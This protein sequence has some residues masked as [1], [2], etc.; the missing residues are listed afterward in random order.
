[1]KLDLAEILSNVGMRFRYDVDEP[2][3]VDEDLECT[4]PVKGNI[5]FTNTGNVLLIEGGVK[6]KV[7][8]PCSRC[9][10]DYEQPV[11]APISEQF[12]LEVVIT[13]P[14]GRKGN[15][16]VEEDE[17]PSAGKL[18]EGHLLDLTELLRQSITLQIPSQP[19]HDETCKG[20]C[21]TCGRDLNEGPCGCV[22]APA[23]PAFAKLAELLENTTENVKRKA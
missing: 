5:V 20:L 8:V 17:N 13:G 9:L 19:L 15:V 6:T 23:N 10:V 4:Q 1:M 2:P 3:I 18:F 12:T 16:T 22:S 21:A 7:A 14:H 11:E